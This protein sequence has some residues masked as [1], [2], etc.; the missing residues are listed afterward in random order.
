MFS[1]T[2]AAEL[3]V[4][5]APPCAPSRD[6]VEVLLVEADQ[7]LSRLPLVLRRLAASA[8]ACAAA[9]ACACV[10]ESAVPGAPRWPARAT[11]MARI[12]RP[13]SCMP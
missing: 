3:L 8:A 9:C 13:C 7:R 6:E 12:S 5:A 1:L 2:S 10:C 4:P 11:R